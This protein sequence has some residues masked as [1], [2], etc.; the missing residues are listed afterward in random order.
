M[1]LL[2]H[3]ILLDDP[4]DLAMSLGHTIVVTEQGCEVL[5]KL[6]PENEVRV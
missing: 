1:V 3:A 5:S 2:L 4:R 6:T